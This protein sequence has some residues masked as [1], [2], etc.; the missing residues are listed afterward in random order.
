MSRTLKNRRGWFLEHFL[1]IES[2]I[3]KSKNIKEKSH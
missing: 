3:M 2:K 1:E